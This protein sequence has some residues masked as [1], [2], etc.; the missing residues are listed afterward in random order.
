[1][2][3]ENKTRKRAAAA[4]YSKNMDESTDVNNEN[5]MQQDKKT[6]TA[7]DSPSDIAEETESAE[8]DN[9]IEVIRQQASE[10]FDG[11]QRERADFL[12]YRKRIEREQDNL[13]NAITSSV[14]LKYLVILDD[15]QL[16]MKNQPSEGKGA[17]WTEGIALIERKLKNILD[18]EGIQ[19][20]EA[21]GQEFDPIFHEAISNED[22]ADYKDDIVISGTDRA[23]HN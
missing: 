8:Q 9:E 21:K 6:E 15:I 2:M 10:Y 11:W 5:N 13:R 7:Q 22:S 20:I 16:A 12:N 14:V 19:K 23:L 1:M 3:E 18:A 4:A 17:T